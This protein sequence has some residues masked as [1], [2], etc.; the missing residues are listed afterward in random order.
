M[1]TR[2]CS[3]LVLVIPLCIISMFLFFPGY[4]LTQ[5]S[6]ISANEGEQYKIQG[7]EH[8]LKDDFVKAAEAYGKALSSEKRFSRDDRREMARSI[9]WGGNLNGAREELGKLLTEDPQDTKTKFM[10]ARVLFWAGDAEGS[11]VEN[12]KVLAA[13]PDSREALLLKGDILRIM[14]KPLGAIEIYETLLNKEDDFDVRNSLS[15]GYLATSNTSE[16]RRNLDLLNPTMPYQH[17][18]VET[19]RAEIEKAE[20]ARVIRQEDSA[21]LAKS[22]GDRLA[23]EENFEAAAEEYVKAL[24]LLNTFSAEEKLQMARVMS[25]GGRL[26]EAQGELEKILAVTPSFQDARVQLARVLLWSGE[27]D[28]SL[29]EIDLVLAGTPNDRDA[30]LVRANAL[31]LKGNLRTSIPLYQDLLKKTDDFDIR[32][33]LTYAY[34][35]NRDKVVTDKNL[36]LLQPSFP[37]QKKSLSELKTLRD[38]QFNPSITPGFTYY[39]DSDD[40]QVWRYFVNGTVWLDNWVMNLGY[41]HTHATSP[42]W[43]KDADDALLSTY[44][45]LPFYGGVGASIGVAN[46][47]G[48]LIGGIRGDLDIPDGS[49]GV[50]FTSYMMRDTAELIENRIRV[51]SSSFYTAYRLTDRV[52]LFGSYAYNSYTDSNYSN[53]VNFSAAYI[54]MRRPVVL[55][56]G[57]RFRYMD[58]NRQTRSGYFDPENF[59]S[60]TGFVNL[61]FDKA[62]FYGF[63][64]PYLGYQTYSRYNRSYSESFYGGA[65]LIGYRLTEHVA[66]E[67]TGEGSHGGVGVSGAYNYYQVG[68]G[69]KFTF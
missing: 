69:V 4:G 12:E 55:S 48:Y 50:N 17:K 15:Y 20:K 16:A 43:S 42:G 49:L 3:L 8:A 7:D 11:L 53:S 60:N 68:A 10:L 52:N 45:R 28:A 27:F 56:V 32:E 21:L 61:S 46:P 38:R 41:I 66:I 58:F 26:K 51:V 23:G 57:Y 54:T 6:S 33:G 44:S 2:R 67:L 59:F 5:N 13:E 37:Y 63:I 14:G 35:A 25:W 39:N 47:G 29:K 22:K 31:R 36:S 24:G 19:L 30:L 1:Q 64:E 18:E 40:N 62:R 34:M 65:C 9:A